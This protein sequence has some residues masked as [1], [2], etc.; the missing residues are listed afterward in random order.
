MCAR[1]IVDKSDRYVAKKSARAAIQATEDAQAAADAALLDVAKS[2]FE[3][4]NA[5]LV[6]RGLVPVTIPRKVAFKKQDKEL[7]WMYKIR[8]QPQLTSLNVQSCEL[9]RTQGGV[10]VKKLSLS[11]AM[12]RSLRDLNCHG[13]ELG[14]WGAACIIRAL[15]GTNGPAAL[16]A[17]ESN[18]AGEKADAGANE[19]KFGKEGGGGGGEGGEYHGGG[20]DEDGDGDVDGDEDEGGG[21]GD[22]N[23]SGDGGKYS[24]VGS[25]VYKHTHTHT[26]IYIYI[27]ALLV[28]ASR[29][30]RVEETRLG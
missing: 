10:F 18:S 9:G 26:H 22:G 20:T 11:L 12:L 7:W 21:D 13:N 15:D 19:E 17:A 1:E 28:C 8:T 16:R 2:R 27:I 5:V 24:T 25:P 4:D 14:D 3:S 30:S 23:G 29:L 6:R